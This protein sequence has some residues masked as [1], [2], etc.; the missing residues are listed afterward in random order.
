[1]ATARDDRIEIETSTGVAVAGVALSG[2]SD[3]VIPVVPDR[4]MRARTP[5]SSPPRDTQ[6]HKFIAGE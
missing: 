2:G 4:Q 3:R 6:R 1:M 5:R